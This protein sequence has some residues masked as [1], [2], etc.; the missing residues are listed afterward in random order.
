MDRLKTTL[1]SV[2]GQFASTKGVITEIVNTLQTATR[3]DVELALIRVMTND[4]A[5]YKKFLAGMLVKGIRGQ[6]S[7]MKVI[8]PCGTREAVRTLRWRAY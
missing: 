1:R 2:G 8:V 3:R 4:S 6:P 5:E 7:A